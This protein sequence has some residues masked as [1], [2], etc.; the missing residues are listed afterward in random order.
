[1]NLAS[2][3]PDVRQLLIE[4][5]CC[6]W[7]RQRGMDGRGRVGES[8]DEVRGTKKHEQDYG[9][10]PG[11]TNLQAAEGWAINRLASERQGW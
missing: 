10:D 11:E 6:L 9:E 1:M 2:L 8:R 3:H 7:E 5:R 4:S